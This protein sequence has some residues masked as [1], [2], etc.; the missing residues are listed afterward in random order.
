VELV[1]A[2]AQRL[3]AFESELQRR[4]ASLC[5]QARLTW[6]AAERLHLTVRFIGEV[7]ETQAAAIAAALEAPLVVS[8]F[9]LGVEGAG[10]FPTRGTPRVLWVGISRGLEEMK[11]LEAEV[12][13]RLATCGLAPEDRGYH[14]HLTLARV[15][16]GSR[17]S[18]A[19]LFDGIGDSRFGVMR[20]DAITLF[21]S[22]L[23]P[24]GPTYVPVQR[25]RLA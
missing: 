17:L 16:E 24:K 3:A 25:T 21:H 1:P 2:I 12:S 23:S 7:D 11:A 14:P 10:A 5:R 8:C 20:V 22:R 13:V 4:T 15:R 6:G 19:R 9:E 18:P